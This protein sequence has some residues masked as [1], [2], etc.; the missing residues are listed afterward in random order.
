[1]RTSPSL[2]P[3]RAAGALLALLLALTPQ[4][5][6]AD[7]L[8]EGLLDATVEQL[9]VTVTSEPLRDRIAERL[10]GAVAVDAVPDEVLD[11]LT[12]STDPVAI[13][14]VLAANLVREQARWADVGPVWTRAREMLGDGDGTCALG[15]DEP[16]GL[17]L[18]TQLQ[19]RTALQL[20]ERDECDE[21]CAQRL[22]RLRERLEETIRQVE[23]LGPG[24]TGPGTDVAAI[25]RD[26]EQARLR[27]EER[28]RTARGEGPGPSDAGRSDDSSM[29]QASAGQGGR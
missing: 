29:G 4:L 22:E 8:T 6:V 5:V 2:R 17:L 21:E 25:L 24:L 19:T 1:M 13:G 11:A 18:R 3:A 15:D 27:L 10:E 23:R 12:M 26:A 28:I 20:A 9:D 16:C 7:E 14:P